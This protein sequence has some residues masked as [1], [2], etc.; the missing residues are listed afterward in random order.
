[1]MRENLVEFVENWYTV[2]LTWAGAAVGVSPASWT[3][4]E[5][6]E[7]TVDMLGSAFEHQTTLPRPSRSSEPPAQPP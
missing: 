2:D 5:V 6:S 7:D 1:M 3:G 4:P